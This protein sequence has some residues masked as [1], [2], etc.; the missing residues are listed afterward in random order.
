MSLLG[1]IVV[2]HQGRTALLVHEVLGHRRAGVGRDVLQ[3]RRVGGRGGDDDGVVHRAQLAEFLDHADNRRF[4]LADRDVDADDTAVLLIDDRVERD[5]RL[6][7][8]AVADDQ[9]PLAATDRNHAVDRLDACLERLVDRLAGGDA[10]RLELQRPAVRGIDVAEPV[11]RSTER[12]DDATDQGIAAG[13]RQQLTGTTNLVALLDR[14]IVAEDD[15]TDG[16]LFQV[17]DLAELAVGELE[18]LTGQRVRQA[19]D[20]SDA[21]TDLENPADL[22]KVDLG[23]IVADLLGDDR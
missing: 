16:A 6:S 19:I 22:G 15:D 11:Q 9:L 1:E 3:G 7:G 21:V 13:N 17:E 2:D 10:R 4:L 5:R 20:P 14:Q 12:V 23:A 8:L 18:L